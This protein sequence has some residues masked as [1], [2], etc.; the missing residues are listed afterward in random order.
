MRFRNNKSRPTELVCRPL[1]DG[2]SCLD[3]G[4][5]GSKKKGG[6]I[7]QVNQECP[8]RLIDFPQLEW[9]S[10]GGGLG[11]GRR[12]GNVGRTGCGAEWGDGDDGWRGTR[13]GLPH[14]PTGGIT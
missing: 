1:D 3:R 12:N 14:A 8:L 10:W 2:Q 7:S 11:F 4:Q 13:R 9:L 6:I 5:G